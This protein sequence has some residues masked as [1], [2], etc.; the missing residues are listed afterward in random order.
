MKKYSSPSPILLARVLLRTD[1]FQGN[2]EFLAS[3]RQFYKNLHHL[4]YYLFVKGVEFLAPVFIEVV[5]RVFRGWGST[6]SNGEGTF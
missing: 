4:L 6:G 5:Y 1:Y 2:S 3:E